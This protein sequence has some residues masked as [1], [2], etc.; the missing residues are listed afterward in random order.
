MKNIKNWFN[1]LT[2]AAKVILIYLLIGSFINLFFLTVTDFFPQDRDYLFDNLTFLAFFRL[3]FSAAIFYLILRYEGIKNELSK[4]K[5]LNTEKRYNILFNASSVIKILVNIKDYEILDANRSAYNF[6]GIK[7]VDSIPVSL[8]DIFSN[9][10]EFEIIKTYIESRNITGSI[11]VKFEKQSKEEKYLEIFPDFVDRAESKLVYLTIYDVTEKYYLEKQ[12]EEYKKNLEKLVRERT[13]DLRKTNLLLERE[14]RRIHLA[15]QRIANQ[16][17]FFKTIINTIPIPI[18]IKNIDGK[19]ID[20]NKSFCDY[21]VVEKSDVIGFSSYKLLPDIVAKETEEYD[22]MVIKN[23]KELRLETTFVD[24]SGNEHYV[25]YLKSPLLKVDGSIEAV[26]GVVNDITEYKQLQ[27]E[28]KKALENEQE[29]SNLK[30]R[31]ISMASHEFRTPLTTILASADLLEM[32]GR[33]WSQE[34]Y[35]E[36]TAKI[37][38]TVKNMVDLLDDVL[39]ISRADTG[40][41]GFNP[42]NMNLFNFCCEVV[43]VARVNK[44][45]KQNIIFDYAND[46]KIITADSKLLGHILNNLLGNAVKYSPEGGD[47]IFRIEFNETDKEINFLIKDSGIGIS[48]EHQKLLFE[49]FQRGENIGKIP[50]TGLGLSI[51]K[52]S[53]DMHNGKITCE[54]EL[55]KGTTFK[56]V[57][58]YTE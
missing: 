9:E 38:R 58:P 27:N 57:I 41:V 53:I 6:F 18:F 2:F 19:F 22:N 26:L 1:R 31:F 47:I 37:R 33:N 16:L 28:L 25:Q 8:K 15:E 46:K 5:L 51:V 7:K 49:P 43:D 54:S 3:L 24:N 32:F 44:T 10:N 14:N 13:T 55:G 30:S 4:T 34:K 11:V 23:L 17:S 21:L 42:V 29:L 20:C 56:I 50:G 12:N 36:H 48:A 52:R 40:K 35:N 45:E 39:I